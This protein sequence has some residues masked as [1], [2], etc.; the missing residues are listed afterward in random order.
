[1]SNT[2]IAAQLHI[3]ELTVKTHVS[4]ILAKFGVKQRS[5]VAAKLRPLR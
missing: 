3:T 2:E 1:M 5:A 4:R